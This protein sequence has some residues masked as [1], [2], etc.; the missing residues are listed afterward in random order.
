[1]DTNNN[2][3][4]TTPIKYSG[5]LPGVC[6]EVGKNV[7]KEK[8]TTK[9][10]KAEIMRPKSSRFPKYSRPKFFNGLDKFLC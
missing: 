2:K 5:K 10:T 9:N 8:Y 3:V 6:Q 7:Y 4:P 1:M